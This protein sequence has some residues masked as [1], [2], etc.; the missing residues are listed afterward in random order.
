MNPAR[1]SRL[2]GRICRRRGRVFADG[3]LQQPVLDWV[4]NQHRVD[5]TLRSAGHPN[6]SFWHR[7]FAVAA[8]ANLGGSYLWGD[9]LQFLVHAA[10]AALFPIAIVFGVVWWKSYGRR[11]RG[12]LQRTDSGFV[13]ASPLFLATS[14]DVQAGDLILLDTYGY[15]RREPDGNNGY[16]W[17]VTPVYR[18]RCVARDV[19]LDDTGTDDVDDAW[20]VFYQ[21]TQIDPGESVH[22]AGSKDLAESCL[23]QVFGTHSV[24]LQVGTKLAQWLGAECIDG[25]RPPKRLIEELTPLQFDPGKG[26]AVS[27]GAPDR[28]GR[29]SAANETVPTETAAH[30]WVNSHPAGHGVIEPQPRWISVESSDGTSRNYTIPMMSSGRLSILGTGALVAGVAFLFARAADLIQRS[31]VGLAFGG[32][33]CGLGVASFLAWRSG[34]RYVMSL[35]GITLPDRQTIQW[36]TLRDIQLAETSV[37]FVLDTTTHRHDMPKYA[38]PWFREE[39]LRWIQRS[40]AANTPV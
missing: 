4:E 32:L 34:Q 38:Q 8:L 13:S 33:V 39:C 14:V 30:E 35:S 25:S 11:F 29:I 5:V 40:A 1:V 28:S 2:L 7:L 24:A 16:R 12:Q 23:L 10:T 26:G 15:K 9:S 31:D 18:L 37:I 19:F 17:V 36:S 27:L 20:G 3:S 21:R 22:Y 6:T